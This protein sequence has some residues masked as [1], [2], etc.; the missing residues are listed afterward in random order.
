[1][2]VLLLCTLYWGTEGGGGDDRA[3]DSF[4]RPLWY[5][6]K[7]E[8]KKAAALIS[9]VLFLESALPLFSSPLLSLP[10][11]FFLLQVQ[12]KGGPSEHVSPLLPPPPPPPPPPRPPR[13][14]VKPP[15]QGERRNGEVKKDGRV[16]PWGFPEKRDP[17]MKKKLPTK[18]SA[19]LAAE[20]EGRGT[21]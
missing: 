5:K 20:E 21:Q 6:K 2:P 11:L 19:L 15:K 7:E 12:P 18:F 10:L 4:Q 8:E 13:L 14:V 1:M 16:R 17:D 9:C 3:A